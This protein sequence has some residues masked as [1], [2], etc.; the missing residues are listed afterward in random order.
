MLTGE[1]WAPIESRG[2]LKANWVQP[3]QSS[4]QICVGKE[5]KGD[6]VQ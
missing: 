6:G 5:R 4:I 1:T 2:L 3:C